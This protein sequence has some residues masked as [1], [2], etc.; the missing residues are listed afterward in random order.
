MAKQGNEKNTD[1]IV[2]GGCFILQ[3]KT[4]ASWF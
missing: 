2:K 1:K 4:A 3:N